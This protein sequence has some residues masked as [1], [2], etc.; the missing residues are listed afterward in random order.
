MAIHS[1]KDTNDESEVLAKL[2]ALGMSNKKGVDI[3][4]LDLRHLP[5]APARFFVICSGNVP[6]HVDAIADGVFETIK[7]ATGQNPVKIEGYDNAE[8]ILLDYFDVMVHVFQKDQRNFYRLEELWADGILTNY[9]PEP[10][11]E[12]LVPN[13][14]GIKRTKAAS[15]KAKA[16]SNKARREAKKTAEEDLM[17]DSDLPKRPAG[18]STRHNERGRGFS[19][20]SRSTRPASK[21]KGATTF[22]KTASHTSSATDKTSRGSA[23]AKSGRS[24]SS[25]PKGNRSATSSKG[26]G[27][28]SSSSTRTRNVSSKSVKSSTSKTS[29]S[30]A[31][32]K[33]I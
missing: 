24:K 27:S 11:V 16:A 1:K 3:V 4:L 25:T 15:A 8:W 19:S 26:T 17:E 10:E 23:V 13:E 7:K 29:T 9:E 18:R 14:K 2:A 28:T 20:T 6:S 5:S 12:A 21:E 33:K 22:H 32:T 31:K 30:K